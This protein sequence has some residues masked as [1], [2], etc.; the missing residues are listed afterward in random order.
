MVVYIN[1]HSDFE[2]FMRKSNASVAKVF[3]FVDSVMLTLLG[4]VKEL[5]SLI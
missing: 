2:N 4:K 1:W 5:I 3:E